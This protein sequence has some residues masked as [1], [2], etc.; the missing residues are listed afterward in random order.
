MCTA[1]TWTNGGCYFG[2]TLDLEYHYNEVA[3]T[4]PR[5][6]AVDCRM[7]PRITA[8]HALLGIATVVDGQPL[9]YDA[10][11]GAGL[12][13]AALNFPHSAVYLPPAH[14]FDNLASFEVIPW[15]LSQCAT[16]D[17]ACTLLARARVIN[18]PFNTTLPPTPLH[19]FLADSRRAVAVEAL[20]DGLHITDNPTCVL[21]NEPPL[22]AQLAHLQGFCHLSAQPAVNRFA[23]DLPLTPHSRGLGGMGLPGDW[24]SPSRFVRA[25][26][27]RANAQASREEQDSISQVF[28]ILQSV[29]VPRG[30][31]QL[32]EGVPPV[33]TVYSACYSVGTGT[34]Y[35]ATYD[36][37]ERRVLSLQGKGAAPRFMPL[38]SPD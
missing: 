18:I 12:F 8:K 26:F 35:A 9:W 13:C 3:A 2:R 6:T 24:S 38:F 34:L 37:P 21:T 33:T 1:L 30:C 10:M 17:E 7:L 28:H 23:P 32:G 5:G 22:S 29:E 4:L 31:I 25:A 16:V 15:V 36:A 11:N 27:V 14:G 20:A 19:W